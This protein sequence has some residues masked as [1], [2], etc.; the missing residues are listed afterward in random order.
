MS[1]NTEKTRV[2]GMTTP[3]APSRSWDSSFGGCR[4]RKP[5]GGIRVGHRDRRSSLPSLRQVRDTLRNNRHMPMKGGG[6]EGE[7]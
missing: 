3:R 5:G 1:L 6:G 7:P 2:V 4:A